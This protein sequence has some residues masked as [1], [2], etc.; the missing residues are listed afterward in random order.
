MK[1]VRIH[2]HGASDVL[3]YEDIPIPAIK[4]NECLVKIRAAALNHLDLWVR[5]GIPGVPT[6]N[7]HGQ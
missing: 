7:D 3:T 1:A 2:K 5:N 6:A 4:P